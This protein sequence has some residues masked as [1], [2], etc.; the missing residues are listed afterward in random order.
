MKRHALNNAGFTLLEVL[1]SLAI[2]LMLSGGIFAAVSVSTRVS[3]DLTLARLE[4][5][6]ADALQRFL[7]QL[8]VNLPGTAQFELRVR[9]A[10]KGGGGQELLVTSA[11]EFANFSSQSIPSG[12]LALGTTSG[13]YGTQV[14]SLANFDDTTSPEDRDRQ[15]RGAAWIGLLPDVTAV[16]WRFAADENSGWQE[17]WDYTKG[18][19]GLVELD[20]TMTDGNHQLWHFLVPKV[21]SQLSSQGAK[22]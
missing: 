10:G 8:F 22:R 13:E 2:F 1:F 7:R 11:P 3:A 18:R 15:L 6:R 12:G 21:Q 17:T 9:S 14:F 19:P 16:R 20:I 5:E 4:D